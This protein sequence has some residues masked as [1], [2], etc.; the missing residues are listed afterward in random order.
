MKTVYTRYLDGSTVITTTQATSE[1]GLWPPVSE[2]Y[3]SVT[4]VRAWCHDAADV[5]AAESL[6]EALAWMLEDA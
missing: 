6:D 2:R 3:V 4:T 1:L 5:R